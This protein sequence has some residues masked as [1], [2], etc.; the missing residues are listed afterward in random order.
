MSPT[1]L[2]VAFFLCGWLALSPAAAQTTPSATG[3]WDSM[4]TENGTRTLGF[5]GTAHLLGKTVPITVRF[6]CNSESGK[7]VQGALGFDL[8]VAGVDQLTAFH[9]DDFEG[10]DALTHGKAL[11]T[12]KVLRTNQAAL[13]FTTSPS[14]FY[15]DAH[16]FVFEVSAVTQQP[17]SKA[18]S[19]LLALAD[20]KAE[21]LR[22]TIVDPRNSKLTLD[23]SIPVANQSGAFKTL[24]AL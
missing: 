11:L 19:V 23:L 21:S 9:F 3:V 5:Q 7:N 18:K 20:D 24:L 6:F 8:Q 13:S 12:V 2:V 16:V 17:K 14:G 15:A 4:R 22:I 1:R 10:P